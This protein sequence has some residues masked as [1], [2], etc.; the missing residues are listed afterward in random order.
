MAISPDDVDF[1]VKWRFFDVKLVTL[2]FNNAGHIA[3]NDKTNQTWLIRLN[4]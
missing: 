4:I 3:D 1:N 2:P